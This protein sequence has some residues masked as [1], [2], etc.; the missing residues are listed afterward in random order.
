MARFWHSRGNEGGILQ[1][2]FPLRDNLPGVSRGPE[3]VMRA[4]VLTAA[5]LLGACASSSVRF[6][7]EGGKEYPG[8][9]DAARNAVTVTIGGKEYSGRYE[10]NDWSQARSTLTAAGG[11][12]LYCDLRYQLLKVKGRCTDLAGGDYRVESR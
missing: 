1:P 6:I 5:L 8:S 10:V 12:R 2:R 4:V 9:V 11:E 3:L 7:D